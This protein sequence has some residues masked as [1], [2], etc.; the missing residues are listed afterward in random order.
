MTSRLSP[1]PQPPFRG[2]QYVT[3]SDALTGAPITRLRDSTARGGAVVLSVAAPIGR[4]RLL[5]NVML[6]GNHAHLGAIE[7]KPQ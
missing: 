6:V 2:V 1:P 3:F 5:D 4:T 7:A